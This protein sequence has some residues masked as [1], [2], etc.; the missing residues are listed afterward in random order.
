M[1]CGAC[2][3]LAFLFMTYLFL[4]LT[5]G[6]GN[7]IK[8]LEGHLQPILFFVLPLTLLTFWRGQHDGER[9]CLGTNWFG[10]VI[11]EG[12]EY[13][14]ALPLIIIF[15]EY[16]ASLLSRENAMDYIVDIGRTEPQWFLAILGISMLITGAIG[17]VLALLFHVINRIVV[18][19]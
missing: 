10:R 16:L 14:A 9:L 8:L 2:D 12:F 6:Q 7:V 3:S 18:M 19:E 15:T 17:S 1:V 4:L 13:G 11:Q 5:S